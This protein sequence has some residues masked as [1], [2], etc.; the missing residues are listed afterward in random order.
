MRRMRFLP[1]LALL[2]GLPLSACS[3]E[4]APF[5]D[6][7]ARTHVNVLAGTI[8]TRPA[9]TAANARAREYIV[10]QLRIAGFE[11]RVQQADAR[12]PELGRTA[13]VHNIIGVRRGARDEAVGL[14]SHYDSSPDAPGAADDALGVAVSL[15]AARVLAARTA[16]AWSLMVLVTDAEEAG[17]MGAAALIDDREVSRRLHAYL[18]IEAAGSAGPAR[19]FETGPGNGWLVEPWAA[20]APFPAGES[21]GVEIYR[22]LPND[23]DFTILARAGVPGLNFG[24]IGDSYAY[25]TARDTPERLSPRTLRE[26]GSNVVAIVQALDGADITARQDSMR[27]YFD[28]AGTTAVAFGSGWF[29][30]IAAA[31]FGAG[32]VAWVRVSAA[33]IALAGVGRWMLT[34]VWTLAGAALV[35]ASMVGGVW[36]L[37]AVREVYHPWYA[38]PNRLFLFLFVLAFTVGWGIVRL[39]RLLPARAHGLR[40]P[41]MTW[42]VALPFWILLASA[43]LWIAPAAAYMWTVPLLAAGLLLAVVPASSDPAVRAASVA[44]LAVAATMWLQDT[45]ELL[46]FMV[47]VFGRLPLV[48]PLAVYPLMMGLAGVMIVPPFVAAVARERPLLRP[49]LMTG[50][51]LLAVSASAALAYVAPAYTFEEPLRRRLRA[52]Q[53]AGGGPA[54]VEVASIEPGLDLP[55]GA[56]EGWTPSHTPLPE[57]LPLGTLAFPFVFRASVPNLGPPPVDV[58]TFTLRPLAGGLE[59]ELTAV[60]RE[61]GATVTFLLPPGTAPARASLPGVVRAGRWGAT[62]VAVPPE[63]IAFRA[64]FHQVDADALRRVQILVSAAGLPGGTGPFRLPA[65]APQDRMVWTATTTWQL[66]PGEGAPIA[67][68]PPLR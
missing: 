11:V 10:D 32:V 62:Y 37:R 49:S 59:L 28:I 65:W 36:A 61:E 43:A 51:L 39:G 29:W 58:T 17:L 55:P 14:L 38:R 53:P 23:T 33:A 6:Q 67:P 18:N 56:P 40:H 41:A 30:V 64:G 66:V 21:F 5:N 16:P 57:G 47:A 9:G 44:V 19:L 1:W 50:I 31:S 24:A 15:E 46:R 42:S 68:V 45:I 54:I 60:P 26:T 2:L 48:T 63:G 52:I 22:R 7:Q 35:A 34:F 3:R 13:R 20:R 27:T 4:P 25:H 12:R 8:G